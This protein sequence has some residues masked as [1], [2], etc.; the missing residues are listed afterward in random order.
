MI[1]EDRADAGRKLAERLQDY[2]GLDTIVIAIPRGGVVVGYEV[3]K[4]LDVPLD[5]IVPRKI[6]APS[7]PELAIGAVAGDD[8]C[9]LDEQSIAYLRVMDEYIKKESEAQRK[10]IARRLEMYRG[11]QPF[12]SLEGKTVLLVDDGVAT[13]Y[14]TMAAAREL[15]K[16]N[17]KKLV[18][19]VPVAPLESMERLRSE[20]DEIV[21]LETPDP[22]FAVGSWYYEFSQTTDEE[23][24][25]LLHRSK[26]REMAKPLNQFS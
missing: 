16:K 18:L 10:E 12:P 23:V 3:A 13:G 5:I 8:V 24:I 9:V 26:E 7:Q 20:V 22:F 4:A 14:T 19:A 25:D 21:V 6:G 15:R 11:D 17:P 2:K 1:F